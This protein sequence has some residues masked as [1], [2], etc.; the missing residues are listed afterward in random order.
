MNIKVFIH[1]KMYIIHVVH[2]KK[3]EIIST[4]LSVIAKAGY[5]M[6]TILNFKVRNKIYLLTTM[7][8]TMTFANYQ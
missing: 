6:L 7:S 4:F 8:L 3:I 1:I 2:Q 5:F